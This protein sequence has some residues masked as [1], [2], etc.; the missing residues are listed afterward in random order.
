MLVL[1]IY[2]NFIRCGEEC[3]SK[4]D[5]FGG[6]DPFASF[7]GDFGFGGS[8]QGDRESPRGGDIVMDT[9]VTLEELYVGNFI[10][11]WFFVKLF[12]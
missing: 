10:E 3:V 5:G 2:I 12:T 9:F 7:F 6:M 11:V 8:P 4:E 1:K